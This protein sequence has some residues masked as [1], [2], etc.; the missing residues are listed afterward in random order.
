[1]PTIFEPCGSTD[2]FRPQRFLIWKRKI[3]D[4]RLRSR[5]HP[6]STAEIRREACPILAPYRELIPFEKF[7]W[8]QICRIARHETSSQKV[9][10]KLE[11]IAHGMALQE[12]YS[13]NKANLTLYAAA[14][15]TLMIGSVTDPSDHWPLKR[16]CSRSPLDAPRRQ[17]SF[18]WTL[19]THKATTTYLKCRFWLKLI[20]FIY[21]FIKPTL[22]QLE[23]I[24]RFVS[25]D[26]DDRWN[27][28]SDWCRPRNLDTNLFKVDFR[29]GQPNEIKLSSKFRF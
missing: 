25:S 13:I 24:V 29:N 19:K 14:G 11:R 9:T 1:M 17:R 15:K 5:L 3:T 28:W 20:A 21:S 7:L 27:F 4:S 18:C 10:E 2:A 16:V 26:L 6:V 12:S 8:A 23:S 22:D